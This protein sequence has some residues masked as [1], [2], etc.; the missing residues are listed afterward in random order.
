LKPIISGVP[1]ASTTLRQLSI[2]TLERSTGFSQNT[3]LPAR[4][5]RSMRSA[6]VVVGVQIRIAST[7]ARS[8]TSSIGATLAPVACA[9]A[10]AEGPC[11]SATAVSLACGW[12]A[13]LRP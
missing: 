1:A 5:P 2:R 6:W 13:A 12:A 7:S 9:S 8:T 11:G 10:A 3:A 4:A